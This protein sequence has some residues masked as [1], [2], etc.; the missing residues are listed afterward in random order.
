MYARVT[1]GIAQP[2]KVDEATKIIRDSILPVAKKQK[3]F[4]KL[5]H[6]GN[7]ST[8]KCIVITMW[9]TEADMT[10]AISSTL[11]KEQ[12]AKVGP[13]LAG[14]GTVEGYEVVVQG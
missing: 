14:P 10:A 6:L 5:I 9:N 3:G 11:M 7:R 13:L 8:G 12:T 2:D 4:K 1:I